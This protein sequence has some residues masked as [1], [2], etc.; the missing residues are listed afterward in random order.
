MPHIKDKNIRPNNYE[1]AMESKLRVME[2]E[3][4]ANNRTEDL[5][6][7]IRR[8]K[9]T[10]TLTQNI[11]KVLEFDR[12][13][14]Q[15]G[16]KIGSRYSAL[17]TLHCLCQ[18]AG[19]KP[20]KKFSK[21]NIIAFLDASKHRRFEDRRYRVRTNNTEKQLANCTM[22]LVKLR[23]KRFFQWLY[24]MEKGRYPECVR[25]IKLKTIKGDRELTPEDL[26]TTKEVKKMIESTE[27]PRDRALVSLLAE[28]GARVGEIST[29]QL[30]DIN[31]NDK[32]FILSLTGKTGQRRI[33]ICVCLADIKSWVNNFH[34]F[35]SDPEAPLFTSFVYSRAWKTN[36]K[37]D[38]IGAVVRRTAVRAGVEER[39]HMHPHK[40]RHF[41]ASQLAEAGWNEPMLRQYFGWAKSSKMPAIYIHM[42]QKSMNNRYYK[43]YGKGEPEEEKPQMLEEPRVCSEC[44][45]QNPNGYRFCFRCSAVLDK[46]EQKRIENKNEIKNTLNFIA[47]DSELAKKFTMLLQEAAEKQ[48]GGDPV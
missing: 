12:E 6:S 8:V 22:S 7:K 33:P 32:G 19:K 3:I 25:W 39:I 42:T 46:E 41:R 31:W 21:A 40:F 37:V 38:G 26:P 1:S 16:H 35:K 23:V 9:Q 10:E 11:Q 15:N 17:T 27:N 29:I 20:F 43:M 24:S 30:K 18:F 45:M 5:K 14:E 36:L 13:C 48:N 47:R 2:G 34:P 28:S 44:G 4:R